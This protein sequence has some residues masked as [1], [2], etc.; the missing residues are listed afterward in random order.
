MKFEYDNALTREQ[1]LAEYRNR[2]KPEPR[3]ETVPLDRAFGRVCAEEV[4]AAYSLPICRSSRMDGV[5]VHSADFA[6]GIPDTSDWKRGRDFAQAD[7]GDDFPDEFDAVLSREQIEIDENDNLRIT[8]AKARVEPGTGVNESGATV[9]KGSSIVDARTLLTPELVAA[10]AVGGHAQVDV[11]A[12]PVVAFIPTGTELVPWGSYPQRGQNFEA[13]SLL[14]KGL[15]EQWGAKAMCYP[16][17]R[18]DPASLE[19]A[20]DRALEVADI[21]LVNGGSSRGE[22]DFNSQM[23]QRRGSYFT[24]GVRTVPGRPVGMAI[25]DDTPVVNVPGPVMAAFLSLDWLVRGLIA[26]YFGMPPERRARVS[27]RLAQPLAKRVPFER[28]VRVAL[29]RGEDGGLACSTLPDGIGVPATIAGSDAFLTLPIGSEGAAEGD[30]V[31]VEL[32][33]PLSAIPALREE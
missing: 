12:R 4:T 18:D 33:R 26:H 20:L 25:I 21:V 10:I 24:H 14:V 30:E 3:I 22:E 28:V 29:S 8:D 17:V 23:L 5:A 31:E 15:V 11:V 16:I 2:W 13:N 9:K 32:L 19:A 6:N 1:A 27:A 7:T